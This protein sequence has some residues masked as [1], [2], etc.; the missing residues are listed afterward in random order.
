MTLE[1]FVELNIP[2]MKQELDSK[3]IKIEQKSD[4]LYNELNENNFIDSNIPY[5]P[6]IKNDLKNCAKKLE[7]GKMM[8]E[9]YTDYQIL[10]EIGV[11]FQF[12]KYTLSLETYQKRELLWSL[13][14]NF[15]I[16]KNIWLNKDL[17]GDD[18]S[19]FVNEVSKSEGERSIA[20]MESTVVIVIVIFMT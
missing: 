17:G 14:N 1:E 7:K 20:N 3:I 5:E 15:I 10:F 2:A 8:K 18:V 11:P 12:N 9:R 19:T 4:D 13:M 16:N 6:I